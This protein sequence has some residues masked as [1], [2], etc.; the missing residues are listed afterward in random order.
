MLWGDVAYI[1]PID[2]IH[3]C[4][5]SIQYNQ[6]KEGDSKVY[7]AHYYWSKMPC[8]MFEKRGILNLIDL[9]VF[10]IVFALWPASQILCF[11]YILSARKAS[12]TQYRNLLYSIVTA[13]N[14]MKLHTDLWNKCIISNIIHTINILRNSCFYYLYIYWHTLLFSS[15]LFIF[16]TTKGKQCDRIWVLTLFYV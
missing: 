12:K 16:S 1:T 14:C 2:E 6:S 10:I 8:P 3:A 15:I 11:Q 4:T 13:W 5:I 9:I 7:N